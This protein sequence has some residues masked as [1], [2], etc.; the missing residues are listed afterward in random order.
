MELRPE[1]SSV[2]ITGMAGA[3]RNLG[4]ASEVR[5]SPNGAEVLAIMRSY[6]AMKTEI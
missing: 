6:G 4:N 5:C 2:F 3:Y 1:L